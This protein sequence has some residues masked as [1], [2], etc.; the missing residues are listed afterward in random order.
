LSSIEDYAEPVDAIAVMHP[1]MRR[2]LAMVALASM[3]IL[4]VA[5]WLHPYD[6]EGRPLLMETHRQLGLPPCTFKLVT[7]MPCPSCGMTTSFALMM[8]G[9]LLASMRANAVGTILTVLCMLAIPWSLLCAC[10]GRLFGIVSLEKT[11]IILVITVVSLTLLRWFV[12]I[13]LSWHDR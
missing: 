4:G 13:G 6:E 9:D 2:G 8:H 7:G 12:V 3:T 10:K 11:L 1:W 5:A